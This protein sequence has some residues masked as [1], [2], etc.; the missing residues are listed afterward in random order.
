M[1]FHCAFLQPGRMEG[2][3]PSERNPGSLGW[4]GPSQWSPGGYQRAHLECKSQGT[5]A[6]H[7]FPRC[8]GWAAPPAPLSADPWAGPSDKHPALLSAV[9]LPT[10]AASPV[11]CS[12]PAAPHTPC[13][14]TRKALKQ[15]ALGQG[16]RPLPRSTTLALRPL[17]GPWL[18]KPGHSQLPCGLPG[19]VIPS[20]MGTILFT[21]STSSCPDKRPGAP[22]NGLCLPLC[23]LGRAESCPPLPATPS[24]RINSCSSYL[25]P[26]YPWLICTRAPCY[27]QDE[28][29]VVSLTPVTA[30]GPPSSPVT[31][32]SPL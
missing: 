1:P 24:P 21:A 15:K 11:G 28:S 16:H 8:Q 9:T 25:R 5:G 30:A 17:I 27:P 4:V 6:W 19:G 22:S 29:Q 32:Y 7:P 2:R 3:Q 20:E 23:C 31:K 18:C 14:G 26:A 12:Y 10:L 13:L